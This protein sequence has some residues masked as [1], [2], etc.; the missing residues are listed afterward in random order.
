MDIFQERRKALAE[1][2]EEDS[3][4]FLFAGK[5]K[6]KSTDNDYPFTPDR[7][8]YYITGLDRPGWFLVLAKTDG[9]TG[10]WLF[11]N[12]PDPYMERYLGK[13][14]D[15]ESM[16]EKTG[17]ANVRYLDRVDWELGRLL[18]RGSFTSI[19]FDF[20]K[21]DLDT[22]A[23]P[24]N[25]M[26]RRICEAHP[27]L[28]VK[29]ISKAVCNMRRYKSP[30]EV[31]QIEQAI[32]NTAEGIRQILDH[33]YDGVNER[34]LQA[35]YEFG[36][37]MA[38][39]ED[40][41]FYPIVAGGANSVYLHYS[42]N[43]QVIRDG[44]VLLLDLGAEYGYYSADISRT[45]PISGKFTEEQKLYY[46]AVLYGQQKIM[47]YIKPGVPAAKTLDVAREAIG[48]K[49]LEAGKI[50]D[51]K[52]MERL[53]PHGVS[54]YLGLDCHDVGDYGLI[55]PGMVFTMEPGVYLPEIGLGIRIEDD[56]LVTEDGCR[57]L[58]GEIPKTVEEIES[59]MAAR[60]K[61]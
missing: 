32:H 11:M 18:D 2:L 55:E 46:N 21:R 59:Y 22:E 23:Y 5:E 36:T 61:A 24:E 10:E 30:E 3:I 25:D 28:T 19:Y 26:C 33:L 40:Q 16:K 43:N 35:Y 17:I 56:V 31:A 57:L 44:G 50:K 39:S 58:S 20:H 9:K 29:S 6:Q 34:Q 1:Q 41:G 47:E 4:C 38:G 7:N 42:D 48:E 13:M 45:F 53:L 27:Y 8:Y 14:P 37:R 51:L 60:K 49:L 12:R 15:A 52:E 54:H